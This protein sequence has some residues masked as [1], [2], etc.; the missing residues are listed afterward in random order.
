MLL[1]CS[2]ARNLAFYRAG[3]D[4]GKRLFAAS[5]STVVLAAGKEQFHRLCV[6]DWCKIFVDRNAV[7]HWKK[8]VSDPVKFEAD[9]LAHLGLSAI[10]FRQRLDEI[11]FYRNKFVAHLDEYNEIDQGHTA[12]AQSGLPAVPR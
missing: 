10:D 1:C 2:F 4:Q 9:L 5:Q 11:R 8:T 6:L 3:H 12:E 7:H